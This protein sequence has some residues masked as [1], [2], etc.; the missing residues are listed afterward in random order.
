MSTCQNIERVERWFD[1]E[2]VASR[3]FEAHLAGCPECTHRLVDL[4]SLRTAVE[5]TKAEVKI[6]DAQFPSFMQRIGDEI[7]SPRRRHVGRWALASALTAA[8]VVAL[9][10]ISIVSPGPEPLQAVTIEEASTEI[11]GATTSVY[12]NEETTMVW[13]NLPDG[14]ML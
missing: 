6:S 12:V 13:I 8:L 1:G 10:L 7:E 11:E 4:K 3:E 5:S 9:S 14:D 2:M